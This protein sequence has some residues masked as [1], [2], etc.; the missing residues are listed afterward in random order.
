MLIE[1]AVLMIVELNAVVSQFV[2]NER[3]N[4]ASARPRFIAD[5]R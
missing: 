4:N 2:R 5:R 1:I 3:G